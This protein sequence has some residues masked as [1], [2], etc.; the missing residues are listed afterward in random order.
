MSLYAFRQNY[1][2]L[3]QGFV[4]IKGKPQWSESVRNVPCNLADFQQRLRGS[5]MVRRSK[6]VVMPQLPDKTWDLFPVF[7]SGK[8][9][10]ALAHPG[11]KKAEK[12]YDLDDMAFDSGAPIDGELA[13]ARREL[14]EAKAGAVVDFVK[15][16]LEEVDKIVVTA[17][18][19]T[20][21]DILRA[22]LAGYG[23]V[24]MDGN[25]SSGNKQIAVDQFQ[26]DPTIKIILG[27]MLP[28]GE[29]WTLTAASNVVLAEPSWVPGQNEQ[30]LDRCHRIGQLD[31]VIGWI[32]VVPDS[33]DERILATAIRKD[34]SIYKALDE[35]V[36]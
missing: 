21:L 30:N 11:W 13:T 31:S 16:K 28:L 15:D 18:H 9:K 2:E 35:E 1:Y 29:G 17:W 5:I 12:L 25:T 10:K 6:T 4:T 20:V 3:G 23:L 14:G 34:K 8:I 7:K 22:Q 33:L 36:A 27:Q 26:S 19:H 24:Y 32:P